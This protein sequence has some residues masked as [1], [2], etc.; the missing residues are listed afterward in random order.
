MDEMVLQNVRGTFYLTFGQV[1][2]PLFNLPDAEAEIQP[3]V[4][5]II[6]DEA[7]QRVA[8]VFRRSVS[9]SAE[10]EQQ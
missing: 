10:T 7:M 5:L 8:A 9:S 1:R 3:M 4:R 6:S 2:M